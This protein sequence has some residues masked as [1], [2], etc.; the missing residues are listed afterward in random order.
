MVRGDLSWNHYFAPDTNLIVMCGHLCSSTF[1]NNRL[2][3]NF[4]CFSHSHFSIS[5][6]WE[7][8]SRALKFTHRK[9]RYFPNFPHFSAWNLVSSAPSRMKIVEKKS[10][11]D[12]KI[13]SYLISWNQK[14]LFRLCVFIIFL[15]F[16]QKLSRSW[17]K[18][19][20]IRKNIWNEENVRKLPSFMA[21]I[22]AQASAVA[23]SPSTSR[24]RE[25]KSL[26]K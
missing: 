21:M 6:L 9:K 17:V 16:R 3:P 10:D 5:S 15:L 14:P 1:S 7:P 8:E 13:K 2:S 12:H 25:A 4:S 19:Q 11:T 24:T 22:C 23:I 26:C 18:K 20:K